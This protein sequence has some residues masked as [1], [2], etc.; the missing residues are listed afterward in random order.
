MNDLILELKKKQ[1]QFSVLSDGSIDCEDT[2][3]LETIECLQRYKVF[4]Y[5][6]DF[7]TG[8]CRHHIQKQ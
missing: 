1:I 8:K 5:V 3:R 7:K 6:S 2:P 4:A